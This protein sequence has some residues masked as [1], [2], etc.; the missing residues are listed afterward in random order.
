V[1]LVANVLVAVIA[2]AMT[3]TTEAQ[4]LPSRPLADVI[5]ANANIYTGVV[6]TSSSHAIRRAEAIAVR[7]GR[8]EAVGQHDEIMK[9]KGPSTEVIDLGGHFVMPGFNDAH[10]HLANAGFQR[11]TVDLAGVKS[12]AE[13][14][15]RI[16]APVQNA[17]PNEWIV[18]GGW[19]QTL[20]P[21]K[22]TPQSLGHR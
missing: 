3:A 9:L 20:W 8:V 22:E 1:K 6:D 7:D 12:L 11:L 15:D 14:R 5:F 16:R 2:T 4:N 10:M 17:A 21:V 19:D 13:F 18:G